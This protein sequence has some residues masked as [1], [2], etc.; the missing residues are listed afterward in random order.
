MGAFHDLTGK[1]SGRLRV[2]SESGRD[3]YGNATWLCEC[4]CGNT[5]IVKSHN[6]VTQSSK[7]CGCLRRDKTKEKNTKHGMKNTRIYSIWGGMLTRCRNKNHHD[8]KYYGARGIAVCKEWNDFKEFYCWSL[9]HGY[10]PELTIDRINNNG[11]YEPSNCKWSTLIEQANNTRRC[12]KL[13]SGGVS[14]G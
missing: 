13:S 5:L 10:S 3:K 9:A 7:S 1:T 8:Y 2:I 14:V 4:S 6:I 12:K 11:N